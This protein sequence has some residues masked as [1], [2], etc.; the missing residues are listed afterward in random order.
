MFEGE[1]EKAKYENGYTN[2]FR[3]VTLVSVGVIHVPI[4]QK[5]FHNPGGA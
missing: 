5:D 4:H 1:G 2:Q 3:I